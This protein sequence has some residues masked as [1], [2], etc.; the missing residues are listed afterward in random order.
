MNSITN[1]QYFGELSA[2]SAAIFWSIAVIIFKSASR[3]L[4]P[5]LITVLKNTIATICFI[6]LFIFLDIPI[7]YNGFDSID[8]V[9]IAVSGILG[10]GLADIIF[11]YALSQIGANRIALINCFEPVVIY[12]LSSFFLGTI[13]NQQQFLGFI[14]VLLAILI[15]TYEKDTDDLDIAIKRKGIAL[16]ILAVI[17]SSSGIVLIKPILNNLTENIHIQL[18]VTAFRLF[19]GMIVAWFIF[20]FQKNKLNLFKP[21]KKSKL[22][23]KIIISSGLG[24]FIALSF[25]IVGY[26]FIEHP[27]IASL[28]GQTSIIFIVI[29]S[30]LFLKEKITKIRILS[31]ALA[32]IGV[33]LT[34]FYY[35][36]V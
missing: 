1:F 25:W 16:Q 14:I 2:L 26:A 29:L 30:S 23:I 18:W 8:Y 9:K 11:L 5:Y 4:S 33:Y 32:I 3:E 24:T 28:L 10:M 21:L 7:W 20:Y 15:M 22:L 12:V 34:S 13:L 35:L 31:I 6:I 17:L 19:P 27:P 36:N